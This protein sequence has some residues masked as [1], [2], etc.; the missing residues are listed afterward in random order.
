M[1]SLLVLTSHLVSG[2]APGDPVSVVVDGE[3]QLVL[4]V[5]DVSTVV[6][7]TQSGSEFVLTRTNDPTHDQ[8]DE[9]EDQ[10]DES[11][12]DDEV[13]ED[14]TATAP[15]AAD[16]RVRVSP[17][18]ASGPLDVRIS[19]PTRGRGATRVDLFDASGRRVGK[20]ST[21]LTSPG[22]HAISWNAAAFPSGL[23]FVR[24]KRGDEETVTR[25]LIVR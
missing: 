11:Q 18:P 24:A 2:L 17:N 25:L 8:D 7:D 5:S 13:N 9:D 1:L 22:R 19:I 3:P 23:Y 15:P 16:L 20:V 4:E 21:V 6:F 10:E 12:Q 14:D